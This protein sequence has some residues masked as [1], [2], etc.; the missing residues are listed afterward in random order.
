MKI[1]AHRGAS[2][3]VNENSLEAIIKAI[4]LGSD[5]IE[6]DVRQKGGKVV[7]SHDKPNGSNLD[8][9]E[10]AFKYTK[11]K[12]IFKIDIK[13]K[14]MDLCYDILK[15]I[16]KYNMEKK[17][18]ISSRFY[19]NLKRIK[20][21]APYLKIESGGHVCPYLS[22]L[23]IKKAKKLNAELVGVH[24]HIAKEE[25]IDKAHKNGLEVHVWPVN[26]LTEAIKYYKLG[27]DGVT[28]KYPD[29]IKRFINDYEKE[30][31]KRT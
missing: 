15:S 29:K 12:C 2:G 19:K 27:V 31:N 28:T 22:W 26:T 8:S 1:I 7:L 25:F 9:L 16:F 11:G 3:Y 14:N 13:E 4:E 20:E 23:T 21:I 24:K 17:V 5:I 10:D 18:I 30:K 6:I